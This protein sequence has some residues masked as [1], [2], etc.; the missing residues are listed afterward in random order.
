MAFSVRLRCASKACWRISG[1]AVATTC[2]AVAGDDLEVRQIVG[3]RQIACR[4]DDGKVAE[5][6]VLRQHGEEGVD[7]ARAETFAEHDAVDVP[8]VEMLRRRLDRE[9][10]D[11]AGALA[12]RDRQRRIG[13]AA[14]D[15]QHGRVARR[16]DM[17][18]RHRRCRHQ[19]AHHGRMQRADAQR[20]AQPGHQ[21]SEPLACA[22]LKER[23]GVV[24]KRDLA[25]RP[26]SAADRAGVPRSALPAPQVP[27]ASVS[28]VAA[29]TAAGCTCST[30][31]AASAHSVSTTGNSLPTS[32]A[33]AKDGRLAVDTTRIGPCWDIW[34]NSD[35]ARIW[36]P[37]S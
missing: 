19:P 28:E 8:D 14:A 2:A 6:G 10:A 15:Q 30:A 22:A 26:R 17:R 11:H 20:G 23:N 16:I 25:D 9:R 36:N 7:H 3:R 1:S 5:A 21:R 12:K 32:S 29:S 4:H 34:L 27:A 13:A 31:R 33:A 18:Q 35:Q 37:R 24:G